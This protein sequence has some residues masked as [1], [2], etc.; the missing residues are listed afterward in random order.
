MLTNLHQETFLYEALRE[1]LGR[2]I[3]SRSDRTR[4]LE[5]QSSLYEFRSFAGLSLVETKNYTPSETI[6]YGA[7]GSKRRLET[8]ERLHNKMNEKLSTI[9]LEFL[10]VFRGPFFKPTALPVRARRSSS[11]R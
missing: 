7:V 4:V 2:L 9:Q 5:H 3:I 11:S 10:R 8:V 1:A 6:I